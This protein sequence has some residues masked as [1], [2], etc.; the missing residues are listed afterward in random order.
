MHHHET[1][2]NIV[3]F[4]HEKTLDKSLKNDADYAV[5]ISRRF[6]S[7]LGIWNWDKS[8]NFSW[9]F[10]FSNISVIICYYAIGIRTIPTFFY[11]AL[12]AKGSAQICILIARIIFGIVAGTKYVYL[13]SRRR[14]IEKCISHIEIDWLGNGSSTKRE[15]MLAY[16]RYGHLVTNICAGIAF[17]AAAFYAILP[18]VIKKNASP[19]IN[20]NGT[21]QVVTARAFAVA[22]HFGTSR[23]SQTPVFEIIYTSQVVA[24]FLMHSI[25]V[26][27]YSLA[28]AIV[29]HACGQLQILMIKLGELVQVDDEGKEYDNF[30]NRLSDVVDHHVRVLRFIS[31]AEKLLREICLVDLGGGT[32]CMCIVGYYNLLEWNRE[33]KN[34]IG[35]VALFLSFITFMFNIYSFC[36]IGE[37]LTQECTKVGEVTYM[38]DW[39]RLRGKQSLAV[40]LIIIMSHKP[41]TLTAGGTIKLSLTCFASVVKSF[42]G[43][44]N[45][46]RTVMD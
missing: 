23:A 9:R 10:V 35:I 37:L 17:S 15:I 20:E 5:Q 38:I 21:H 29:M 42:M 3:R 8:G 43:Y 32:I 14:D 45:M 16:A 22:S 24:T 13:H 30:D 36:Y 19:V 46:L 39:H 28:V 11:I 18:H 1:E 33:T 12:D 2:K 6:L 7:L 4:S 40:C 44:L 27:C 26:S 31:S 34:I 25:A 41:L